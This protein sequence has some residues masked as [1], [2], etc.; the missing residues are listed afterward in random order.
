[1]S[2]R[3]L[4][5]LLVEDDPR[6]AELVVSD[7]ERAGL[8]YESRR[9]QT[10]PDFRRELSDFQPDIVLSDFSMPHFSGLAAL[11]ILTE[12]GVDLPLIFVS[13]TIGEEVAVEAMK[14]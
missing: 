13:G 4:R 6:D 11:R 10:E 8:A 7:I 3:P 1:M 5:L 14:S 12:I 2:P 9:V